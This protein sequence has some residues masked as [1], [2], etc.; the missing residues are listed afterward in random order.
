[1]LNSILWD[2]C[3]TSVCFEEMELFIDSELINFIR[4]KQ[5]I[6]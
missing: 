3:G 5:G 2:T 1:M 6:M 4:N